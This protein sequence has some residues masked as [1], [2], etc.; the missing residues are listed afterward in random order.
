MNEVAQIIIGACIVVS[1]I[2]IL[3]TAIRIDEWKIEQ[4]KCKECGQVPEGRAPCAESYAIRE[5]LDASFLE[6]DSFVRCGICHQVYFKK[7]K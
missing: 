4:S 5:R 3:I 2:S 1:G 6:K 7:E